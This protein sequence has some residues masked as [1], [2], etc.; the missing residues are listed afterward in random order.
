MFAYF[1]L[2]DDS[3]N[4]AMLRLILKVS[5]TLIAM[6]GGFVSTEVSGEDLRTHCAECGLGTWFGLRLGC[7]TKE[8]L[9]GCEGVQ[10][11]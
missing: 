6:D 1:L 11:W 3:C 4:N 5:G 7:D 10:Y 2:H 8:L 9:G